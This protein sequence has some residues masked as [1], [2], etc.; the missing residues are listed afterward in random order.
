MGTLLLLLYSLS[1]PFFLLIA[2]ACATVQWSPKLPQHV[3]LNP[4]KFNV[5]EAVIR[6]SGT[7]LTL[8][9]H[10]SDHLGSM[11]NLRRKLHLVPVLTLW[12]CKARQ[13]MCLLLMGPLS[14]LLG[15]FEQAQGLHRS[16]G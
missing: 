13:L 16:G 5:L 14:K 6:A 7:H 4:I 10:S 11:G 1:L 15:H 3:V 12:Q 8:K 2:T 9:A